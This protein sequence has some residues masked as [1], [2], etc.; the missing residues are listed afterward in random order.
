MKLYLDVDDTL[1]D[2]EGYIKSVL[3]GKWLREDRLIYS[4][5]SQMQP[6]EMSK[7]ITAFSDYTKIPFK[8][9]AKEGLEALKKNF[10][11]VL[12]S[13]YV[14]NCEYEAKK[15]LAE[16]LGLPIILCGGA[17]WDKSHINMSGSVFVDNNTRL[18][19]LSNAD[20][21]VC[22]YQRGNMVQEFTDGAIVFDWFELMDELL[23]NCL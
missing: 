20:K 11:V 6:E 1:L 14:H 5:Y 7:V 16:K 4:C 9:G 19:N 18:L 8:S 13:S 10:D 3:G 21:K 12:C 2:T 17:N 23:T 15:V 22:F